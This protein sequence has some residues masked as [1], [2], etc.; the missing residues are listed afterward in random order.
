MTHR[1]WQIVA[2]IGLLL[3]VLVTIFAVFGRHD[4]FVGVNISKLFL[5]FWGLLAGAVLL[6]AAGIAAL[7]LTVPFNAMQ[8]GLLANTKTITAFPDRNHFL[9]A[10]L[11]FLALAIYGSL[12]PLEFKPVDWT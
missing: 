5:A 7:G 6:E 2:A 1:A 8:D 3:P 9:A 12:V 10:F 4:P 11:G